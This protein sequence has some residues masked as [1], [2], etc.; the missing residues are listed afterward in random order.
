LNSWLIRSN[1]EEQ[2]F[3]KSF[4][5]NGYIGVGWGESGDL[6]GKE[7]DEI[8]QIIIDEYSLTGRKVSIPLSVLYHFAN[9]IKEGDLIIMPE[10]YMLNFGVVESSYYYD[11]ENMLIAHRR[12]VAWQ[13]KQANRDDLSEGLRSSLKS[14]RT[15]ANLSAYTTEIFSFL[16][17]SP[18]VIASDISLSVTL[19]LSNNREIQIS[20]LPSRMA[21]NEVDAVCDQIRDLYRSK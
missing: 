16:E 20:G 13:E 19:V 6:T 12:K 1:P 17:S 14:L 11:P 21:P 18:V 5:K 9:D 2:A 8:R 3:A 7:Y 4:L 10:G 15:L